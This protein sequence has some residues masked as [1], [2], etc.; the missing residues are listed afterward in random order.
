MSAEGVS[1]LKKYCWKSIFTLWKN[2]LNHW[3][4]N[5]VYKYMYIYSYMYRQICIINGTQDSTQIVNN[6]AFIYMVFL[7]VWGT[8]KNK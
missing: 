1:K 5:D 4:D 6:S 8:L 7:E 3:Y 2:E